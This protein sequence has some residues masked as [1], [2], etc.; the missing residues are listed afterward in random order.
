MVS[1]CCTICDTT[2]KMSVMK[3]SRET[4]RYEVEYDFRGGVTKRWTQK[5]V[6]ANGHFFSISLTEKKKFVGRD[7]LGHMNGGT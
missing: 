4:S 5:N 7:F 6:P 3:N 1:N 2:I